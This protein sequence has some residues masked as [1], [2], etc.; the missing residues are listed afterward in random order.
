MEITY[1]KKIVEKIICDHKWMFVN[2]KTQWCE[3]CGILRDLD[4]LNDRRFY[5]PTTLAKKY[6]PNKNARTM[7]ICFELT[8]P[9]VGSWNGKWTGADKKYY[10]FKTVSKDAGKTL[11]ENKDRNS[12][13]H[14]F[15]DGWGALVSAE[16]VTSQEKRKLSKI[17]S[18]FCGYDWMVDS[19][20][21]HG[22]IKND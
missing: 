18:G 9:N 14:N 11:L 22:E 1:E 3:K 21:E 15:G 7:I 4:V 13:Y 19:I 20:L 5:I 10:L 2:S 12:W 8:M 17:S 6:L 16:Q